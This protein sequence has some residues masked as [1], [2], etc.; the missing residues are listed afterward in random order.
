M[1]GLVE[2]ARAAFL[3]VSRS[4]GPWLVALT[5]AAVACSRHFD[6]LVVEYT[7]ILAAFALL[8]VFVPPLVGGGL[9]NLLHGGPLGLLPGSTGYLA[10]VAY[11]LGAATV[12]APFM[13]ALAVACRPHHWAPYAAQAVIAVLA[14]TWLGAVAGRLVTDRFAIF[15][16]S[17]L[18]GAVVLAV[19]IGLGS[20][21]D[22]AQLG[23]TLSLWIGGATAL[24]SVQL[25]LLLAAWI[26]RRAPGWLER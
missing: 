26:D 23:E 15:F 13:V 6:H 7:A 8:V 11:G 1:L 12:V 18:A 24:T 25:L 20:L 5:V 16:V 3:N 4:L 17:W 22:V 21:L 14:S 19:L 9:R 2:I 10:G